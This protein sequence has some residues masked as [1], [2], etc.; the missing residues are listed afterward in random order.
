MRN[1]AAIAGDD[2]AAAK[3]IAGSILLAIHAA[4][5]ADNQDVMPLLRALRHEILQAR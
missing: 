3:L 1:Q 5:D 4:T 2:P